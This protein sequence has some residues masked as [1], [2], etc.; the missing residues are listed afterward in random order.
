MSWKIMAC[1]TYTFLGS[2][3]KLCCIQKHFIR[4]FFLKKFACISL[5][6]EYLRE[7]YVSPYYLLT[8]NYMYSTASEILLL[9]AFV[10]EREKD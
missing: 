2:V 10:C 4:N 9:F 7:I 5:R 1:M 8:I 3:F 6:A